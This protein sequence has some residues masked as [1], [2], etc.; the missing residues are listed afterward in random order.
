MSKPS[1]IVTNNVPLTAKQ[2]DVYNYLLE[3]AQRQLF[4]DHEKG[5][6]KINVNDVTR[7]APFLDTTKKVREFFEEIMDKKFQFLKLLLNHFL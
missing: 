5:I 6:F 4:D 1:L 7:I 3:E 2:L